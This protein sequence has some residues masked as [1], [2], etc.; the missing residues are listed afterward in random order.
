MGFETSLGFCGIKGG[1]RSNAITML[2]VCEEGKVARNRTDQFVV[3]A[4]MFSCKS[5]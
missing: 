1:G 3:V 4:T 5:V 2:M